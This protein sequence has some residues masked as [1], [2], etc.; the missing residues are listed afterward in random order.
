MNSPVYFSKQ[1]VE[2]LNGCQFSELFEF[3][4]VSNRNHLH[5]LLSPTANRPSES[6][7]IQI[8]DK[9]AKPNQNI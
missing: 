4:S 3:L 1:I 8:L 5:G 2:R 6:F 7:E 9:K